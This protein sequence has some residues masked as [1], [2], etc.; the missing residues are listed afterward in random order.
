MQGQEGQ[1]RYE[2]IELPSVR[3][4]QS[5]LIDFSNG[6][7]KHK[8]GITRLKENKEIYENPKEI[9]KIINTKI[10]LLFTIKFYFEKP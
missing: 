1:T 8:E 4:N 9:T 5:C 7:T 10:C 6:K 3:K 2:K